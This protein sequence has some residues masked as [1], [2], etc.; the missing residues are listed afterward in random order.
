MNRSDPDADDWYEVEA[1]QN[2]IGF[3]RKMG[4]EDIPKDELPVRTKN[5]TCLMMRRP[6]WD[7][8][9]EAEAER[10]RKQKEEAAGGDEMWDVRCDLHEFAPAVIVHYPGNSTPEFFYLWSILYRD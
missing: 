5:K 9:A 3:W 4:F 10:I 7:V 1:V 2:A 8:A 6:L